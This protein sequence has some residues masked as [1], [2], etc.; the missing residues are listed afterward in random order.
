MSSVPHT[1]PSAAEPCLV[2]QVERR[3]SSG[4]FGRARANSQG[5]ETFKYVSQGVG[6]LVNRVRIPSVCLCPVLLLSAWWAL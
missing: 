2:L 1:H 6:D 4:G 3:S 5:A